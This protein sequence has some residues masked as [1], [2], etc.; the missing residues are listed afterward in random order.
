MRQAREQDE[1]DQCLTQRLLLGTYPAMRT[2][3]NKDI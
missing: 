2:V 1:E 3:L